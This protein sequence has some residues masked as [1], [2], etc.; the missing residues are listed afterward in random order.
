MTNWITPEKIFDGRSVLSGFGL[1]IEGDTIAEIAKAPKEAKPI[2]GLVTPGFVDLQVNGG[3]GVQLNSSPTVQAMKTIAQAHRQYGTIAIMVT[4]ITDTADVINRAADAAIVATNQ[5]DVIGLHIEGPHIALARKGTHCSEFIRPLD[6]ET[7]QTVS[8][9]RRANVP[10]MITLAPESASCEQIEYL[11]KTG[12]VVSIGHTDATAQLAQK[13][14][15]AGASCATHLFNAMSPMMGREPGVV[16]A[17]INSNVYSGI[18]CD[19]HHVA[20]EMVALAIRARPNPDRIFLV[21]DAM[22]TVGGPDHFTLYG[23]EIRLSEGRLI[24]REGSLAGAHVTQGVS[25][26]RLV[27]NTNISVETA[28]RMATSV[29]AHCMGLSDLGQLIGRSIEDVLVMSGDLVVQST[30]AKAIEV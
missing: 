16:G 13:A 19:G 28:L 12:A 25:V 2:L 11:A 1:R 4:I 17:V 29:P 3:G 6:D 15:E 21:S 24:N 18:I 27:E 30:L 14:I 20:D 23:E 10:V 9:L 5:G 7:L 22:A 26:K 8:R